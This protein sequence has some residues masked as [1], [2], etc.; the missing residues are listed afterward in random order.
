MDRIKN[1]LNNHNYIKKNFQYEYRNNFS[2]FTNILKIKNSKKN[3]QIKV[4]L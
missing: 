3:L 2:I 4:L 1:S